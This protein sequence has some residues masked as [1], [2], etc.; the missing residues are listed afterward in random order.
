MVERNPLTNT[1]SPL[2]GAAL[3]ALLASG[4]AARAQSVA[5]EAE[6]AL[7]GITVGPIESSQQPGR[8][9]GTRYS[10]ELLDELVRLGANSISITPF[11]RI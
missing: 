2:L 5:A 3:V 1:G 6:P 7:R 10:A 4:P 11:G 9:Y 8:G